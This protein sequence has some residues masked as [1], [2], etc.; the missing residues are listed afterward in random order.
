MAGGTLR[1]L[2]ESRAHELAVIVE[3]LAPTGELAAKLTDFAVRMF[4]LVRLPGSRV[5]R[6]RRRR[7]RDDALVAGVRVERQP[8]GAASWPPRCGAR[9]PA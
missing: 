1:V 7:R 8:H 2:K 6:V 4:F 3:E 5:L 9:T